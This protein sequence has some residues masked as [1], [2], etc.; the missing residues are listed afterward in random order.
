VLEDTGLQIR[1]TGLIGTYMDPHI[2]TAY[3]D[4]EVRQEF[5]FVYAVAIQ[6]QISNALTEKASGHDRY[7]VRV[8]VI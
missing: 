6:S 8:D 7:T 4:G 3:S 2:L 5:T 1:I